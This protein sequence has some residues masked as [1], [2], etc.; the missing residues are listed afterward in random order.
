[1]RNE[2]DGLKEW[3]AAI[4]IAITVTTTPVFGAERGP[5]IVARDRGGASRSCGCPAP[6]CGAALQATDRAEV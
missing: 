2:H 5:V 6:G 4:I 1:M 3:M